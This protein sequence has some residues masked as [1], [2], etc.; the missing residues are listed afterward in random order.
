MSFICVAI[1]TVYLPFVPPSSS[2]DYDNADDDT[3]EYD[4]V[5]DRTPTVELPDKQSHYPLPDITYLFG[6]ISCIRH[7]CCCTLIPILLHYLSL[8]PL[9][10]YTLPCPMLLRIITHQLDLL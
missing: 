1:I 8:S 6:F 7:C 9:Y 2:I 4:Y 3:T 5:D 10:Y